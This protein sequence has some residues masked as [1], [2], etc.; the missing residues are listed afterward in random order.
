MKQ[1]NR[2]W[3]TVL[4]AA[5]AGV[6][7]VLFFTTFR[8]FVVLSGSM[9]PEI[10]AG[11]ICFVNVRASYDEIEEG[12]I[13][14]FRSSTGM[15]VTHRAVAVTEAGVET[16]GDAND[17]SDGITT[18]GENFIGKTTAS[19]PYL[20]YGVMFLKTARGKVLLFSVIFAAVMLMFLPARQADAAE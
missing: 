19:V 14:A 7:F 9:E 15:S 2:F 11:S 8:P 12:D 3:R 10:R 1:Q 13:I 20:G 16:K 4:P 18:T 17:T 6:F 5:A